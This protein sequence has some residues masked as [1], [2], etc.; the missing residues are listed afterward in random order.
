MRRRLR[1]GNGGDHVAEREQQQAHR[2][3]LVVLEALLVQRGEAQDRGQRGER[4]YRA[5][6]AGQLTTM[7][8]DALSSGLP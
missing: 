2:H 4:R 3:G 1:L 6:W 5:G 7:S 8:D